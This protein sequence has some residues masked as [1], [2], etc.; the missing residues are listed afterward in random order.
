MGCGRVRSGCKRNKTYY[1]FL[2]GGD[3]SFYFMEYINLINLCLFASFLVLRHTYIKYNH[4]FVM[5][6]C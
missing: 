2:K 3:F 5:N 1:M 6:K 4:V